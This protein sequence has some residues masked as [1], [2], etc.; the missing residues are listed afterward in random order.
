MQSKD[1]LK[2]TDIKNRACCYF[3]DIIR[4]FDV[5]F[6]NILL[7]EKVYENISVY[8]ISYKTLTSLKP[9]RIRFNKIDGFI[10]VCGGEFRYLVLF[11]NRLFDKICDSIKYLICK[12]SGIT[13][14][15][16][17]NFGKIRI[18]SYNYLP[19]EKILTFVNVI[20][21]IKLIVNKNKN[22]YYYSIFLEKCLYNDKSDT[23][24]F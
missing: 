23:R 12:G 15:I 1:E 13:G 8:V 7:D 21:L 16:S 17:Y 14:S 19:I 3:D 6:D 24:S 11:N 10:R 18:D 2:E 9:L 22:E 20:K 4:D 5:S